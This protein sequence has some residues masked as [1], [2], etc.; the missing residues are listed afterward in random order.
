MAA[1]LGASARTVRRALALG[2]IRSGEGGLSP[3][4]EAYLR[5]SWPPL[6]GLR[7]A[8][9]TEPGLDAAILFGSA[10]RG[11][12]RATSDVDVAVRFR[13]P[14]AGAPPRLANRLE[15]QVER[16]INHLTETAERLLKEARRLGH[17]ANRPR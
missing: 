4:E 2:T 8:L 10:A 16:L 9:R 17:P 14:G 7:Q 12:D 15:R 13:A 11:E 6:G 1:Q 3:A 5:R